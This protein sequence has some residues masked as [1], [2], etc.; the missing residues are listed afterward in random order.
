MFLR[1]SLFLPHTKECGPEG[2]KDDGVIKV[3]SELKTLSTYCASK[4]ETNIT[5]V[6]SI[7]LPWKCHR[8]YIMELCDECNNCTKVQVYTENVFRDLLFF[9]I[10]FKSFCVR[11]L[12]SS[13]L[14]ISKSI[15]TR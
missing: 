15:I 12:T 5:L 11:N 2:I 8:E 1:L 13:N 4:R 14:H 10:D 6:E 7:V 9:V 3:E